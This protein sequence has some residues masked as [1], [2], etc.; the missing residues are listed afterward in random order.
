MKEDTGKETLR[1]ES[2]FRNKQSVYVMYNH[3][4]CK[5]EVRG[6]YGFIDEMGDSHIN[7]RLAIEETGTRAKTL[8][9]V[10]EQRCFASKEDLVTSLTK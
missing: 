10:N 4:V 5:A 3:D 1:L 2:K 6:M 8:A 9:D 7:L